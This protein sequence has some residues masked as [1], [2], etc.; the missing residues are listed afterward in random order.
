MDDWKLFV[1][2]LIELVQ[3]S[4]FYREQFKI[5]LANEFDQLE[6]LKYSLTGSH[7]FESQDDVIRFLSVHRHNYELHLINKDVL[8]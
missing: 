5:L 3:Y 1:S 6:K 4:D 8:K 7:R 2:T